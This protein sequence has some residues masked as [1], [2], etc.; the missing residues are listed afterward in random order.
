MPPKVVASPLEK[1]RAEREKENE[2]LKKVVTLKDLNGVDNA[3]FQNVE[4]ADL[5]PQTTI[6]TYS[7]HYEVEL[8]KYVFLDDETNELIR[9]WVVVAE[10]EEI[11][12]II[13][14]VWEDEDCVWTPRGI[15]N[16]HF[17]CPD[18]DEWEYPP[19][20]SIVKEEKEKSK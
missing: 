4:L 14:E 9:P 17:G 2:M 8:V 19:F 5:V 18:E 12:F 7:P 20:K 6:Y 1:G 10:N 11:T 13:K 15:L 3:K 16:W